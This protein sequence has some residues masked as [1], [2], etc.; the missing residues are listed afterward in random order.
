MTQIRNAVLFSFL[1]KHLNIVVQLAGTMILTRILAPEDYGLYT[2]A[3]IFILFSEILREFGVTN[4]LIKEKELTE[5]K[6]KSSFALLLIS[7]AV[8]APIMYFLAEPIATFY[9][10]PKL[11]LMLQLLSIN[12]LLTPFGSIVRSILI[13]NLNF[14]AEAITSILSQVLS[15]ILMIY[16]AQKGA[17]E[18]TLV[19]GAIAHTFFNT[20]LLQFYRPKDLPKLPGLKNIKDVFNFSKFVGLASI[21]GQLGH[22]TSELIVGKYYS[23]ATVGQLNRGSNTAGLFNKLVSDALSPVITPYIS[24]INRDKGEN[25]VRDKI[26]L[27]TNIQLNLAWPFFILV[28]VLA[29][30][31]VILLFGE[32]WIE[33]SVYLAIFCL[34]RF[35]FAFTQHLNPVFLGVGLVKELMKAELIVNIIRIAAILF[36]IQYGVVIMILAHAIITPISRTIYFMFSVRK[37]LG[38]PISEYFKYSLKPLY[39]TLATIIPLSLFVYI[40]GDDV[41]ENTI[42]FIGALILTLVIWFMCVKNQPLGLIVR[43]QNEAQ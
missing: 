41:W 24:Q 15:I 7:A 33:A 36:F 9:E 17:E 39:S 2:I 31:I 5:D 21:I 43:K 20:L 35:I 30:P 23:M 27:L 12:L 19:Y 16:L 6:I 34:D 3:Y 25:N 40:N 1:G 14:K 18:L 37:N 38:I 32:Q 28:A 22:H 11:T 8:V 10:E 13:R 42:V 4:Y 26:E 29:K